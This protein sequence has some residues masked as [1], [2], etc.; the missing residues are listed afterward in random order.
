MGYGFTGISCKLC[1]DDETWDLSKNLCQLKKALFLEM[2][3]E[4]DSFGQV[5]LRFVPLNGFADLSLY[6]EYMFD[7]FWLIDIN[8]NYEFSRTYSNLPLHRKVSISFELMSIDTRHFDPVAW[9]VDNI[10]LGFLHWNL[11][12]KDLNV[13]SPSFWGYGYQ[14]MLPTKFSHTI[15]HSANSMIF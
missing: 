11:E 5:Q 13:T 14:D 3:A 9:S 7:K 12:D 6:Y 1:K 15:F 4:L 2:D 8:K 10:Y